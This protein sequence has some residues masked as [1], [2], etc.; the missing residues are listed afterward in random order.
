MPPESVTIDEV[1]ETVVPDL[2]TN[3][4]RELYLAFGRNPQR[5]GVRQDMATGATVLE[6]KGY[7]GV[8]A[9]GN[10]RVVRIRTKVPVESIFYLIGFA[11]GT[12]RFFEREVRYETTSDF[13]EV[14]VADFARRVADLLRY[15]LH[16][17]Y[18]EMEDD[19]LT[20]LRG[21]LLVGRQLRVNFVRRDR[22]AC[23]YQEFTSDLPM[24]R[25]LKLAT[26]LA[27]RFSY[28]DK[29][30]R[31][32]LE[33]NLR[34]F[35]G[36]SLAHMD[37]RAPRRIVLDRLTETY[38]LPL[39]LASLI[40]GSVTLEDRTGEESFASYLVDMA[41]LFEQFVK[42]ILR[43]ELAGTGLRV[44]AQERRDLDLEGRLTF[45]PD[46]TVW[47]GARCVAVLDTKYKRYAKIAAGARKPAEEDVNQVLVYGQV[48]HAD[49]VVLVY[50]EEVRDHIS[51]PAGFRDIDVVGFELAGTPEEIDARATALVEHLLKDVLVSVA[52]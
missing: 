1:G 33:R 28:R 25:A 14:L 35:G 45:I 9:L 26:F 48:L 43:R 39:F 17:G 20:A 38:R 51:M 10:G 24:N 41:T 29:R 50:P 37:A 21:R 3:E 8:I 18:V 32:Q 15:G 52:A 19:G 47:R 7:A 30:I 22:L 16:Q 34:L 42:E 13:W 12:H 5:I 44:V 31:H 4:A 23:R 36:V 27:S 46:I 49:R 11:E 40:I 2:T 6:G